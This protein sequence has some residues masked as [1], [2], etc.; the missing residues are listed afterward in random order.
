MRRWIS[1][2]VVGLLAVVGCGASLAQTTTA[3]APAPAID[4][5]L[6]RV[7]ALAPKPRTP[8][9][10]RLATYNVENLFDN[11]DDPK[12]SG[13]AEDLDDYKP[14]PL[15]AG[16]AAAIRAMDADVIALQEVESLEALIEFRNDHLQG[17]GYDYVVSIDAGDGRGIE[18]SVI[19]RFP[20]IDPKVW[21][22][23]MLEGSHPEKFADGGTIREFGTPFDLRRSPLRA[24]VKVPPFVTGTENGY[25]LTLFVVHHKSG[26]GYGYWR[27]AEAKKVVEFVKEFESQKPGANIAVLGDF[28]CQPDEAPIKAYL[29]AGMIDVKADRSPGDATALTHA[30]NRVIDLILVNKN[31]QAELVPGSAF[32]LGTPQI[33]REVDWRTAPKP[34][35]YASD[36]VPVVVDLKPKDE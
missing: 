29:D 31:L 33:P 21:H 2:G 20:V 17:M 13:D 35:G 1:A 15:R 23:V 10:I 28:N 6:V 11:K 14:E 30:S 3:P 32:V 12:L 9:A 25:E 8:G 22:G 18:Q 4:T 34:A 24:T 19:S 7:G 27:E 36:H 5:S 26:R 16:L